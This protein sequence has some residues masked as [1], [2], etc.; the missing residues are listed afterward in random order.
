MVNKAEP[1]QS[2]DPSQLM[3]LAGFLGWTWDAFDFFT[4]SL[5]I[6]EIAA[7]FDVENSAVSWVCD[8]HQTWHCLE[9]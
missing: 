6:T 2:A 1:L 5:T 8:G 7:D 3:F 9:G 4:V